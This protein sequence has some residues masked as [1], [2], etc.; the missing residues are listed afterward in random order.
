MQLLPDALEERVTWVEDA[1]PD[2]PARVFLADL[3]EA[4]AGQDESVR[5]VVQSI[6]GRLRMAQRMAGDAEMP[7][8]LRFLAQLALIVSGLGNPAATSV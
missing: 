2:L 4:L 8:P 1:M 7:K 3:A 6:T 5:D